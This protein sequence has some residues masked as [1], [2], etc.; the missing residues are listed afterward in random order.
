MLSLL[1][2]EAFF[3][4]EVRLS[5]GKISNYYI[6]V[7]KV[8]LSPKGIYLIT[9]LFWRLLRDEAITA[10]GGPT[11]GADPIVTGLC[12]LAYKKKMDWKGFLI[13]KTPKKHGQQKLI[14][15]KELIPRDRVVLVDDVATSGASL[16]KAIEILKNYKAKIVKAMVVVDREEGAKDNLA[17][18]GCP[19]FS[20]FGK[21]DFF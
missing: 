7:R 11:L 9:H 17:Q 21:N 12:M 10:V 14:E 8:S 20:I 4:K 18:L 16:L 5:S 1:R 2:K 3:K 15:G 6:D 19:L 13:R